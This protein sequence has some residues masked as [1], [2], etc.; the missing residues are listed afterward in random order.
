MYS[1]TIGD[2]VAP[3]TACPTTRPI[4][5]MAALVSATLSL[6]IG[7]ALTILGLTMGL[8]M[9]LVLLGL[10]PFALGWAWFAT[11]GNRRSD[12][13]ASPSSDSG[14][15]ASTVDETPVPTRTS[16]NDERI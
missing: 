8:T 12:D 5:R 10:T 9:M 14:V 1:Q 7:L 6:M 15:T 11:R 16:D 2:D 3:A 13:G 4:H